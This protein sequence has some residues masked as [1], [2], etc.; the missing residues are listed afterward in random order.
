MDRTP[1]PPRAEARVLAALAA[2]GLTDVPVKEFSESTATAVDAALAIGTSVERIVKSLVFAAGDRPVLVLA[3]G[4]NRVDVHKLGRLV[5]ASVGRANASQVRE[6]TGFAI[7]GVPPLGHSIP[8]DTYLDQDLLQYE[9]V[10]AALG[11]PNTVFAIDPTELVRIT[12]ARV[13]EVAQGG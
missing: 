10:W 12:G 2:Q 7:G 1:T 8:I 3:S 11:T 6:W 4:P 9:R 13:A 5:G